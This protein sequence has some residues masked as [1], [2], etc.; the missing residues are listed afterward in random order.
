MIKNPTVSPTVL[1]NPM[2]SPT[3]LKNPMVS[4]TVLALNPK[5]NFNTRFK[6]NFKE[7]NKFLNDKVD[8]AP[9]LKFSKAFENFSV[10]AVSTLSLRNLLCSLKFS[11]NLVLKFSLGFSASTVGLTIGFLSTVGLTIGFLSTV[12]LTVGFLIIMQ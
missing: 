1:K 10:G 8:T 4:P 2:V 11:L 12:G 9:T 7:H 6:L 3:V 5:L